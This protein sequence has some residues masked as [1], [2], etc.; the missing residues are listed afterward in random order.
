ME[1]KQIFISWDVDGTLVLGPNHNQAHHQAFAAAITDLFAP[2]AV[3]PEIFLGHSVDGYMD[4]MIIAELLEKLGIEANEENLTRVQERTEEHYKKLIVVPA[5]CPGI[6]EILE[7]LVRKK[8][9]T[10]GLASGNFPAIAWLKLEVTGLLKY[11]PDRIGGLGTVRDRK[12]A[13]LKAI[14]QGEKVTGRTFDV[15]IHVGDTLTDADAAMRA[16]V[17]PFIVR[18]G[19]RQFSEWP[20]GCTIVD[21]LVVGREQFF[22]RLGLE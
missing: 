21:N 13:I 10:I 5:V 2:L 6:P 18:T 9:V 1:D 20:E 7:Y 3:D 15:K 11:F 8:N 12:D 19:R 17:I 22:S 16:G 14:A 4:S